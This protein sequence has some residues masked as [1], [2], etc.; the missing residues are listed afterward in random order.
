MELIIEARTQEI[1]AQADELKTKN[2]QL[3]E[4]DRFKQ[5][6]TTMIV[7]DFKNPLSILIHSAET[8][9]ERIAHRMLNL[10]LNILDVQKFEDAEI[11]LNLGR[12]E[13]AEL[14]KEGVEEVQD[15]VDEKNLSI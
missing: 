15:L 5:D 12:Y 4:L 14:V 3:L 2:Q 9:I 10:V 11:Q 13:F 6:V 7:H 8:K 1:T